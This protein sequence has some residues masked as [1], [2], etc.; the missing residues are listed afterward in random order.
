MRERHAEDHRL[1]H[2]PALEA[3]GD[4]VPAREH[5]LDDQRERQRG[6]RQVDAGHPQR[7]QPDQ[8][9]GGR[10]QHDGQ[11]QRHQPRQAEALREVHVGVGSDA[12][13]DLVHLFQTMVNKNIGEIENPRIFG[14]SCCIKPV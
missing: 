12:E 1:V 3:P 8:H 11:R 5:F 4:A 14:F 9:T 13:D 7:R 2:R 10:G 6:D